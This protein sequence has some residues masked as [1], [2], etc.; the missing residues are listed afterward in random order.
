[1]QPVWFTATKAADLCSV[2]KPIIPMAADV[3]GSIANL[4][5]WGATVGPQGFFWGGTW[6]CGA[7]G[8]D[9]PTIV[10]DIMKQMTCNADIMKE[11]V[12]KDD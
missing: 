6:I 4:G 1:M 12:E 11:I 7:T 8:T 10:G 3:D 5:G 9:N 2:P